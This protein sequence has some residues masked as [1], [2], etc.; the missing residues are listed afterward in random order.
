MSSYD[1][2][3]AND[4]LQSA[5]RA[6]QRHRETAQNFHEVLN[7]CHN[8]EARGDY[9]LQASARTVLSAELE[10]LIML[11]PALRAF[12]TKYHQFNLPKHPIHFL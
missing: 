12:R 9:F 6:A 5:R 2:D 8:V 10:D 4:V 11:W 7:W 1:D 3:M